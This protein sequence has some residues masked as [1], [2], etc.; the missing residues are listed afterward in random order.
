MSQTH[1][2]RTCGGAFAPGTLEDPL[3]ETN[4]GD[5]LNLVLG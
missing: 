2:R 1:R 4:T 3:F 5:D